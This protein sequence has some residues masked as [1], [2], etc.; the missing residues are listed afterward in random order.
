MSFKVVIGLGSN[1]GHR[2]LYIK[3]AIEMITEDLGELISQASLYQTQS[4]GYED[5]DYLNSAICVRT[6]LEPIDLM[7]A[8]LEIEKQMGRKPYKAIGYQSR[9]IDLD[10]LLIEG[11][12]INSAILKVPHPRMHLR[13]FVLKPLSEIV[14]SWIHESKLLPISE[15]LEKCTDTSKVLWYENC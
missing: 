13:K 14:P 3:K 11:M 9:I 10:I 6:N 1:I 5:V 2:E 8:L 4:W 7:Q 12:I 15:L